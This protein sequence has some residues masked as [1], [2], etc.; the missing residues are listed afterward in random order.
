M[1]ELS[2]LGASGAVVIVVFIFLKYM[3]EER[4]NRD[5]K[6]LIFSKIIKANT[7][8]VSET[9]DYIKDRNGRDGEIHKEL[10]KEIH[11]IPKQ[12]LK[13]ADRNL[14][15]YKQMTQEIKQQHVHSQVVDKSAVRGK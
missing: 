8:T 2:Q 12:M 9:K 15:A 6:D 14:E 1:P 10:I 11:E 5:R 4:K 7:K 13:V 3:R